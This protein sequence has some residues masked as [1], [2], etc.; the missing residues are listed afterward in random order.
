MK[1]KKGDKVMKN[2]KKKLMYSIA[3]STLLLGTTIGVF[4]SWSGQINV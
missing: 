2:L 3:V 4:A 1:K